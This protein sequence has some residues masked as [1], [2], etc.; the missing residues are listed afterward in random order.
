MNLFAYG[1]LMCAEIMQQVAGC[2][3]AQKQASLAG[4]QRCRLQGEEY[5]A[6]VARPD[7]MV[8]GTVYVDLPAAAW[9]RLDRFEGEMY[10]RQSV[11]VQDAVGTSLAVQAYVIRPQYAH[12]LLPAE[13]SYAEFLRSGRQRFSADYAGFA[14]LATGQETAG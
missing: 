8:P 7:A 2:L 14:A 13:W 5:P 3:P 4:Y 11:L 10:D 9:P 6:I 1:T 12:L